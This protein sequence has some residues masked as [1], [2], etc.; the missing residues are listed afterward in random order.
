MG[1]LDDYSSL[2]GIG[3]PRPS[4]THQLVMAD[5]VTN[6]N[7]RFRG[8]GFRSL[9]EHAIQKKPEKAPDVTFF[10]V[11]PGEWQ[12]LVFVEI[13]TT[14]E[15]KK[16]LKESETLMRRLEIKEAFTYDYQAG[17]WYK[18]Y[19]K[20]TITPASEKDSWCDTFQ[21]DLSTFL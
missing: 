19:D 12:P 7:N 18:L 15:L 20:E 2:S 13:T 4:F 16:I 5:L 8:L 6:F 1:L 21:V 11:Q 3:Q 14:R 10:Q 17:R 9:S